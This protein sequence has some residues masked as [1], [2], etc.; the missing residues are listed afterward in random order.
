VPI[1]PWPRTSHATLPRA[2]ALSTTTS[3]SDSTTRPTRRNGEPRSVGPYSERAMPRHAGGDLLGH[4]SGE[5]RARLQATALLSG[6]CRAAIDLRPRAARRRGGVTPRPMTIKRHGLSLQWPS[7]HPRVMHLCS[8][9]DENQRSPRDGQ[10]AECAR[11]CRSRHE[12][13]AG[14][15]AT[16]RAQRRSAAKQ[17][18]VSAAGRSTQL[19]MVLLAD[20]PA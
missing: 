13:A 10:A 8:G 20:A 11:R 19:R 5:R 2:K 4:D 17:H 18:G 6:P 15:R 14:P 1:A 7:G 16:G 3:S 12:S 9:L